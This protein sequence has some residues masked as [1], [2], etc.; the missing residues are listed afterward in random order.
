MCGFSMGFLT[1]QYDVSIPEYQ[2]ETELS[3]I[4]RFREGEP[5]PHF[6]LNQGHII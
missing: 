6:S 1:A 2:T 5:G 4:D 3:S